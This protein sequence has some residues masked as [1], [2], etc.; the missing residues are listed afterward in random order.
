MDITDHWFLVYTSSA[1][2]NPEGVGNG[3]SFCADTCD[4]SGPEYKNSKP[5]VSGAS[6]FPVRSS[7]QECVEFNHA[8]LH[9]NHHMDYLLGWFHGKIRN[10]INHPRFFESDIRSP[11][12][13]SSSPMTLPPRKK[14]IF[15][16]D[17]NSKELYNTRY[18][19][20]IPLRFKSEKFHG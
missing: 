3:V 6:D 17:A 12:V 16:F 4:G 14:G 9:M 13:H 2:C 5:T 20:K 7:V 19:A 15:I 1:I 8:P 18:Q 11:S 10:W